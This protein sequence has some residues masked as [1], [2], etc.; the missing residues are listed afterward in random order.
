MPDF[1]HDCGSPVRMEV[2]LGESVP[3]GPAAVLVFVAVEDPSHHVVGLKSQPDDSPSIVQVK[4]LTIA[5]SEAVGLHAAQGKVVR[6]Q[7]YLRPVD[8]F[9]GLART[10]VRAL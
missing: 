10:G 3:A 8:R 7:S 9:N 6:H 1:V 5:L 2:V 4:Q